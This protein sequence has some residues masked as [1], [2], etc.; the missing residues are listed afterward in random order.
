MYNEKWFKPFFV[1]VYISMKVEVSVGEVI[2]KYNI[3]E[4]KMR[5]ISDKQRLLEVAKE[6]LALSDAT[7]YIE[8][9]PKLYDLFT[10][11]N[12][13]IWNATDQIKMLP[14]SGIVVQPIYIGYMYPL[15]VPMHLYNPLFADNA[16][17][18]FEFNQK[19]FRIKNWFNLLTNSEL[20]E[21]K[22][23]AAKCCIVYVD[24]EDTLLDKI[25]EINFLAL[26]NDH[27]YIQTPPSLNKLA[28]ELLTIPTIGHD[29]FPTTCPIVH[30]NSYE[31]LNDNI[32]ALFLV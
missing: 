25:P 11:V 32:R 17:H 1:F 2:D 24:S 14:V 6:L 7:K 28:K 3:L 12:E 15:S 18:I 8:K 16:N 19:R 4:L 30:L 23:F 26:D 21:Q 27:I 13:V 10:Y 9:Y 22:S 5:K 29:D 31:Y 20:K